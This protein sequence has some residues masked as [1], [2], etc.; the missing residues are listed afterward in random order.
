MS[1]SLLASLPVIVIFVIFQKHMMKGIAFS[2]VK[3]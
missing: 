1:G 2:G 3:G